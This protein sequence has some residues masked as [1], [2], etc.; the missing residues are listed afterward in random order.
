MNTEE[1][2]NENNETTL[3][4]VIICILMTAAALGFWYWMVS[5]I[6]LTGYVDIYGVYHQ[7]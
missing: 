2:D 4:D 1:N 3:A 7:M 5:K 6:P